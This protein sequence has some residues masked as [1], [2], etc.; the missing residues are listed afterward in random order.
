[1][2][3]LLDRSATAVAPDDPQTSDAWRLSARLDL[4]RFRQLPDV[5]RPLQIPAEDAG[6]VAV[7]GRWIDAARR[8]DLLTFGLTLHEEG[9]ATDVRFSEPNAPPDESLAGYAQASSASASPLLRVP[10]LIYSA[11]WHRDYGRLWNDRESLLVDATRERLERLN[12]ESAAQFE[13]LG[14]PLTLSE[15]AAQ[16]G[17]GFRVVI[18]QQ[19]EPPYDVPLTDQLP[20]AAVIIEVQDASQFEKSLRP[21]L[22]ALG[23]ILTFEQGLISEQHLYADARLTSLSLP[24]TAEALRSRSRGDYNFRTTYTITDDHVI[25]GTTPSIVRDVIDSLEAPAPSAAPNP[26]EHAASL[27]WLSGAALTGALESLR[28]ALIRG[29]VLDRGLSVEDAEREVN[30]V[31]N[32]V[33]LFADAHAETRFHPDHY[34]YTLRLRLSDSPELMR[35]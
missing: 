1:M 5:R 16:L 4:E 24:T 9:L 20:R 21:L 19:Q 30:V 18:A 29:T 2:D 3:R 35:E 32:L 31:L 22:Q 27:Q 23:L 7:F 33:R 8:H 17:P 26:A 6:L 14:A 34:E 11:S 12:R 28:D 10:G 15:I 25:V 13:A